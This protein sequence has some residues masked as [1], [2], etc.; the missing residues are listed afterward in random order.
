MLLECHPFPPALAVSIAPEGSV[1]RLQ[2]GCSQGPWVQLARRAGAFISPEAD[3]SD[4]RGVEDADSASVTGAEW[5]G[6]SVGLPTVLTC[7]SVHP[8]LAILI[9]PG[10]TPPHLYCCSSPNVSGL[11]L[12][13]PEGHTHTGIVAVPVG[14]PSHFPCCEAAVASSW[15][16]CHVRVSPSTLGP[17]TSSQRLL[18][19]QQHEDQPADSQP[20][21]QAGPEHPQAPAFMVRSAHCAPR[22]RS[23]PQTPSCENQA[24]F[25]PRACLFTSNS[26]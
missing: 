1:L 17:A 9:P 8:G 26:H 2:S 23:Q 10:V 3:L 7:P 12:G 21:S 11:V 19:V 24:A 5:P 6:S 20:T 18:L 25:L 13:S 14:L 16:P 4:G 15:V 22:P